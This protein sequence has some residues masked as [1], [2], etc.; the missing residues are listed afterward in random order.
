MLNTFIKNKG[1]TQTIVHNNNENY[2]N[3]INWD[4]DYDGENASL[5]L[6]INDNGKRGIMNFKM[7]NDELAELLN[8]PSE[9]NMLDERLYDDFLCDR[10]KYDYKIIEINDN[11]PKSILYDRLS[12]PKDSYQKKKS[13]HFKNDNDNKVNEENQEMILLPAA[14]LD[15]NYHTHV[16]SPLPQEELLFPIVINETKT[17]KHKH[18]RKPKSH[19]T[20][21]VY[22][23]H[24]HSSA[25]SSSSRKTLRKRSRHNTNS[26]SRRTF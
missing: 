8:I 24:R 26:Y 20:H 25:N 7:N 2:Y 3:Q 18:H 13:V 17:R 4:A 21:K 6:D 11:I 16:S 19:L 23:K 10:P 9:N 12:F 14:S 1:I 5:S 22:R 15:E